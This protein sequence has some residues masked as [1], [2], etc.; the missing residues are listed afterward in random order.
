MNED[1][2]RLSLSLDDDGNIEVYSC[3]TKT[4]LSLPVRD[5][6]ILIDSLSNFH[7]TES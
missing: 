4:T 3:E 1:L 6:E 2:I 5:K 7:Q